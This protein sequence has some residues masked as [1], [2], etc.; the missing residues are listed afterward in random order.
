R[1]DSESV[2]V[3]RPVLFSRQIFGLLCRQTIESGNETKRCLRVRQLMPFHQILRQKK[4]ANGGQNG[5]E[6]NANR[7]LPSIK[8]IAHQAERE[9]GVA[10]GQRIAELENHGGS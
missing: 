9:S 3:D 2:A 4:I 1:C 5:R 7:S 10:P 6:Q 8:E